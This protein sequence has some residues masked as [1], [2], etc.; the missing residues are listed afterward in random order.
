MTLNRHIDLALDKLTALFERLYHI[1]SEITTI[2]YDIPLMALTDISYAIADAIKKKFEKP[3][4]AQEETLAA[5]IERGEVNMADL[6]HSRSEGDNMFAF[7]YD[8]PDGREEKCAKGTFIYVESEYNEAIHQFFDEEKKVVEEW[9][10][11]YGCKILFAEQDE[12]LQ[13]M[14]YPQERSLLKHGL[15]YN[16]GKLMCDREYSVPIRPWFYTELEPDN[17]LSL[18]EQLSLI[19]QYMYMAD[20]TG[21]LSPID[22]SKHAPDIHNEIVG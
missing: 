16:G 7:H 21:T 6:P 15:L 3:E 19:A 11:K 18:Q 17:A 10:E 2:L 9:K 4:L 20:T 14:C 1:N 8:E 5:L 22:F 12:F 13:N